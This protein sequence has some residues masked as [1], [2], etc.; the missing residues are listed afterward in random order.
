MYKQGFDETVAKVTAVRDLTIWRYEVEPTAQ[1]VT[2]MRNNVLHRAYKECDAM[3]MVANNSMPFAKFKPVL[4]EDRKRLENIV[5]HGKNVIGRQMGPPGG[6]DERLALA[7][8]HKATAPI[9]NQ[10]MLRT[11]DG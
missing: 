1:E 11:A 2:K 6:E 10:M 8:L 9:P 7:M 4:A 3:N 5:M